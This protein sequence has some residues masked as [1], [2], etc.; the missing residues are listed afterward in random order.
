MNNNTLLIDKN[1]CDYIFLEFSLTPAICFISL[2]RYKPIKNIQKLL[3]YSNIFLYLFPYKVL[4]GYF[5]DQQ[6]YSPTQLCHIHHLMES[7]RRCGCGALAYGTLHLF[8]STIHKR[9]MRLT[10]NTDRIKMDLQHLHSIYNYFLITQSRIYKS[11]LHNLQ[12]IK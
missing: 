1:T 12:Q 7:L 10:L 3:L 6:C 5:L 8:L 9:K 4:S 2:K 11:K